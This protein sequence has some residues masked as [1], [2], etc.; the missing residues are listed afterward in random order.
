M[1]MKNKTV[2]F[3]ITLVAAILSAIACLLYR[4]VMYRLGVVYVLCI[5]AVV[6]AV[7][8]VAASFKG[9]AGKLCDFVPVVNAVLMASAAV[10][11]VN[12]MVNELGYVVADLDTFDAIQSF[13]VFEV[14]AVV[15]LILNIVG[16]FMK[17]HE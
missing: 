5:V 6:F 12:L 4:S 13:I 14:V 2:G 1:M 7:L 15:S 11:G 17:Q 16:S 8:A 9:S 3:Y 10:W